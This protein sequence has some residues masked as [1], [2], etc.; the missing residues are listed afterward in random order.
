[1]QGHDGAMMAGRAQILQQ[2]SAL[3]L[4]PSFDQIGALLQ[5]ANQALT[6]AMNASPVVTRPSD[7]KALV[8]AASNA[9]KLVETIKNQST[10][11][12]SREDIA[13]EMARV[14]GEVRKAR[15]L[16][17]EL[18]VEAELKRRG[19]DVSGGV[20]PGKPAVD[21]ASVDA[22]EV[23]AGSEESGEAAD[24]MSVDESAAGAIQDRPDGDA[25]P[26]LRLFADVLK[27]MQG[28]S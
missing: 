19:I 1:M 15:E 16:D 25:K 22:I 10:G 2:S 8:D 5:A 3:S 9:L 27:A 6:R 12:V 28:G 18:M 24:G 14:L 7:V 20:A 23:D 21:G 26:G 17:V 13:Q 11:K 4:D